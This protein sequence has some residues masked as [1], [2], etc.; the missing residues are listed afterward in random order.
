MYKKISVLTQGFMIP[1]NNRQY[2]TP[3]SFEV[4]NKTQYNAIIT[5]CKRMGLKYKVYEPK[6]IINKSNIPIVKSPVKPEIITSSKP[7]VKKPII[8]PPKPEVKKPIIIPPKPEVIELKNKMDLSK[9]I[10]D[11][12][13]KEISKIE[14]Q[15]KNEKIEEKKLELQTLLKEMQTKS[16]KQYTEFKIIKKEYDEINK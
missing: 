14:K 13:N 8:I 15:I 16:K 9:S 12:T 10:L 4:E 3:V 7:E 11:E 2:R 5:I 6:E 1:F